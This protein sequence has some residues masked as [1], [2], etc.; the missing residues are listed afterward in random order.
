[1]L[2]SGKFSRIALAVACL[3][4]GLVVVVVERAGELAH[5]Q[6]FSDLL[7]SAL[8]CLAAISALALTLHSCGYLRRLWLLFA[9]SLFLVTVAQVVETYYESLA[10]TPFKTPWPSDILFILWV[11]PV[12]IMLLPQPDHGSGAIA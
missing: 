4:T 2:P 6:L 3:L 5:S 1:L 7:Q 12:L 11:I 10:H 8:V 9:V